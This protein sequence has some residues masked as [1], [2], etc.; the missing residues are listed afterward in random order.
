VAGLLTRAWTHAAGGRSHQAIG[1]L[2]EA[3][4]IASRGPMR[5]HQ[6]DIH[7]HRARFFHHLDPYPWTSPAEDL[8]AVQHLIDECQYRRRQPQLNHTRNLL[9]P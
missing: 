4:D 6:A 5:L 2:D 8:V 1:D 3:W 7:L 9:V